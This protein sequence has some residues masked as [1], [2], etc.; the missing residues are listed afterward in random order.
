MGDNM[1]R[2]FNKKTFV[3]AFSILAI[4]LILSFGAFYMWS[5]N[6][7]EAIDAEGIKVEETEPEDGWYVY[8]AADAEKGLI[9]YPGAKVEPQAYAYLAQEL[10]QQ[11][12]TV[13][14][15]SVRLNLAIFDVSKADEIIETHDDLDWYISG[16]S[17]GGA[18]AAMYADKHLDSVS[19]LILLGAYAAG[20]D[21]LNES[22]LP[23]L[24]ISGSEDG[25]S[26]PAKIDEN[27]ANLPQ[28]TEFIE[29][30][31]GN[32]A[33]FGVYGSQSGDNEAQMTVLEQQEII[34]EAIVEWLEDENS[35]G[36]GE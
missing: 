28:N 29:I 10:A 6:T 34:I 26:T 36:L 25:L 15:P 32:H 8:E 13:A 11:G 30:P 27:R 33:Y 5:Q 2:I 17:M 35:S 16:H 19:G 31:G 24:S 22:D 18:A 3:I 12:I 1:K 21:H 23:T 7:F 14:I 9:I 4:V 20:N